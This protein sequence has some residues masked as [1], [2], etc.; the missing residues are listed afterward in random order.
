[1]IPTLN[2]AMKVLNANSRGKVTKLYPMVS[3]GYVLPDYY[4]DQNGNPWSTKSGR[5]EPLAPNYT[6]KYP[7]ITPSTY[8]KRS[9][10]LLHRI[11]CESVHPFSTPKGI[12]KKDWE[13]T[14]NSVKDLL[15]ASFQ[16]NHID[17]DPLNYH[18][19]NLEWVS[20]KGNSN[21]YQEFRKAA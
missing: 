14:P 16:V 9:T 12:T 11:V 10:K 18:P 7:T 20:V 15:R 5:L 13:A 4:I 17:H 3:D 6:Q 8:G 1:M 19:D 2:L 21:A